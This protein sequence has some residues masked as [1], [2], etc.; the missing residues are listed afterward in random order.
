MAF[1]KSGGGKG[2]EVIYVG[3]FGYSQYSVNITAFTSDYPNLTANN[4]FL[5]ISSVD[6]NY[7]VNNW[8][9]SSE[10]TSGG[11]GSYTIPSVTSYNPST[12]V[13]SIGGTI[14]NENRVGNVTKNDVYYGYELYIIIE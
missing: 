7:H 13:V 3:N 14:W 5:R 11:Q 10:Q 2:K 1:I 8:S 12:G 6:V 4:F 9:S